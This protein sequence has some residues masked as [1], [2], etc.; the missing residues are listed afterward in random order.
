M[1]FDETDNFRVDSLTKIK[2]EAL[3]NPDEATQQEVRQTATDF[4]KKEKEKAFK[5]KYGEDYDAARNKRL[6]LGLDL[7]GGMYLTLE[8]DVV[9]LIEEAANKDAVDEVFEEVIAATA[10]TA[11][12]SDM[13]VVDIFIEKFN[14]IAVPQK[15][16]LSDY[17][18]YAQNFDGDEN[19]H[20][21]EQ[22]KINSDEAVDRSQ[23]II[24][25]R[26]DKYGIAE[27]TI[28]KQGSRRIMLE[29]PGVTNEEEMS[30]LIKTTARLE[31]NLVKNN[32]DLIN[33]FYKIDQLLAKENKIKAGEI[34]EEEAPAEEAEVI[35][36][37]SLAAD[38][39]AVAEETAE[40]ANEE[41][42]TVETVEADS[43]AADETAD[44][45]A[46]AED[47]AAAEEDTLGAA[48]EPEM[49]NEE[50]AEQYQNDHPFTSMFYTEYYRSNEDEDRKQGQQ[51]IFVKENL[52]LKGDF[53]FY[54]GSEQLED[55]FLI[56][57]RPD[58]K[59]L[60]PDGITILRDAEPNVN[61]ESG[62]KTYAFYALK[63]E[64]ELKGDVIT[65]ARV[66]YDQTNN[67]PEVTMLMNSD[68]TE[69]WATIT[70]QNIKKRVAIVLDGVVYSAPVVQVKITGG[71]SSIT[72]S[73]D[74][75][76]AKLL[77]I[78][79]KAGALKAPVKIIE[80]LLV[81]PSLGED[82]IDSGMTSSII[83]VILVILYMVFYYNKA[84]IIADIALMMNV[85]L[86]IAVLAAFGGTLTLPGI[87]GIILTIG[88]AV[89][90][91]ILIF[92]RIREELYK[93]RSLRSAVDEG[94]SKALSAILD[95]NITTGITGLILFFLGTGPIQGFA[96]T[97][98]IGIFG[99]LFTG[100]MISRA[101]I[102]I[103]LSK[104]AT[105]FSFGQ[106]KNK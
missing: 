51:F 74:I 46:I 76:E 81:G 103:S 12:N 33:S 9:K 59:E 63:A 57:E 64:P 68:G 39:N 94:F 34:V 27:P 42:E 15:R 96:L 50:R 89:D 18:D 100:I 40:E 36:T 72:G 21:I 67:R 24:R 16:L 75:A 90:A 38:S 65:D 87:A 23:T 10:E 26:I 48:A 105:T 88:M 101:F 14:E 80:E 97:L 44:T 31:F 32:N 78:V 47:T 25:Q 13:E 1:K 71:R 43:N 70:G 35:E 98:I 22:L 4:V 104:G 85:F 58:V 69:K 95:S 8:V 45:A 53:Y 37:D 6:K 54:I 79:L 20:I 73:K 11:K 62:R 52:G 61:S 56:L 49:T 28:Q 66:D 102:E 5:E 93:G 41:I 99:T 82:A 29:L 86:I 83:A 7:R 3:D 17:F 91:N 60:L 106:P 92:E 2:L 84:G 55:F 77:K 30:S 19:E